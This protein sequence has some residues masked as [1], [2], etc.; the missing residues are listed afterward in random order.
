M[1][2]INNSSYVFFLLSFVSTAMSGFQNIFLRLID[3][4]F[5]ILNSFVLHIFVV[6]NIFILGN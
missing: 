3:T 4:E 1:G 2:N 5:L 6:N